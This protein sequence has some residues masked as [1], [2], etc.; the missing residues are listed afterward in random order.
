M[1][2]FIDLAGRQ[3]DVERETL[4]AALA[5]WLMQHG[6]MTKPPY[7]HHDPYDDD[8]EARNNRL[9]ELEMLIHAVEDRL[10]YNRT[11]FEKF[12]LEEPF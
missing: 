9:E 5:W 1:G 10:G 6:E 7:G 2:T 11:D 3:I 12:G 8:N 4:S